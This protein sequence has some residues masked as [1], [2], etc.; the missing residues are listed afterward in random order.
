M[1]ELNELL[2]LREQSKSLD[3][4]LSKRQDQDGSNMQHSAFSFKF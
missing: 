2:Q 1:T 4:R 3:S